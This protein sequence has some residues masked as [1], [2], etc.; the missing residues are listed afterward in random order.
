LLKFHFH[1]DKKID[2]VNCPVH[3]IHG[4]NDELIPY[5]HALRLTEIHGDS[6]ILT[7][8][9]NGGHNNLVT[10]DEFQKTLDGLLE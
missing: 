4:T 8:I 2:K 10:F 7:T 3:I 9:E 5:S 6:N 1:N